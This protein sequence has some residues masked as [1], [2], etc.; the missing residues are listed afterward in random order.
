V[1]NSLHQVERLKRLVADLLDVVRLQNGRLTLSL[2]PLALNE[3]VEQAVEMARQLT[4]LPISLEL[5]ETALRVNGDAGRL[6][7][8]LLNLLNNAITHARGTDRIDVRLRRIGTEAEIQVRDYGCGIPRADL[9]NLFSRFFQVSRS[10]SA[11]QRGLGLGLYIVHELVTAHGG[12]IAAESTEA[13]GC[14]FTIRLPL[15]GNSSG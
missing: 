3:V 11:A 7:Q 13:Q 10:E 9:P 15:L 8:V 2:L 1:G 6:E 4:D 5:A 12:T 14:T